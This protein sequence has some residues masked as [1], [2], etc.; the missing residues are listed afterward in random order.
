[1]SSWEV[2]TTGY[3]DPNGFKRGKAQV[4]SQIESRYQYGE[5]GQKSCTTST[6]IL[7]NGEAVTHHFSYDRESEK[8]MRSASA[9]YQTGRAEPEEEGQ[10]TRI[11]PRLQLDD[12]M[13]YQNFIQM[14]PELF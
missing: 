9:S 7:R 8:Q 3:L 4:T 6:L 1:M 11:M 5:R 12:P 14:L 10:Y 2:V 13:A